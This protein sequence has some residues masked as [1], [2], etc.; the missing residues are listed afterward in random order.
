[1]II[2]ITQDRD[3]H[4]LDIL[5]GRNFTLKYHISEFDRFF[6]NRES[7]IFGDTEFYLI[8]W[9]I[10]DFHLYTIGECEFRESLIDEI[11]QCVEFRSRTNEFYYHIFLGKDTGKG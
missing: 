5:I 1:M 11:F 3:E 8:G 2:V 7:G 4:T 10:S 6:L 9:I